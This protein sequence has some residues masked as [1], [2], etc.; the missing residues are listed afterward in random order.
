MFRTL[1]AILLSVA[2]ASSIA[3]TQTPSRAERVA[4]VTGLEEML[5]EGQSADVKNAKAQ[6]IVIL[7]QFKRVGIP[8]AVVN[9]LAPRI[10]EFLR[11][12]SEAW[13]PKVA[14]RIYAEGLSSSLSDAELDEAERYYSSPE[15]KRAYSAIAESQQKTQQYMT[16]KSN[17]VMQTELAGFLEAVKQAVIDNRKK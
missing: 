7:D 6:A 11:K 13:D 16:T 1:L 14:A 3:Q 15:G 17:Q 9:Q 8:D 2:S 5:S 12:V 10:E 4:R